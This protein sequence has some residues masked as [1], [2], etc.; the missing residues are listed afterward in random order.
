MQ[1]GYSDRINHALAFAAKHHDG[2]VR[3]GTA[4]PYLTQP[5]NVAIILTR[6]GQPE[7]TVVSGILHD[8]VE[9]WV[10]DGYTADELDDRIG[11]KFGTVVLET[12]LA[13]TRRRHDDDGIELSAD[14]QKADY[15]SRLTTA[16]DAARWVCCA[17]L[18]HHAGGLL[19][20]L[21]RTIDANVVWSRQSG[22]RSGTL[23][24]FSGVVERLDSLGWHAPVLDELRSLTHALQQQP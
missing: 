6:Y 9:D 16:S 5:A 19:A 18:V 7:D 8:V 4:A 1:P 17:D 11:R 10:R 23:H 13:V 20:D 21:R 14:E 12:L 22:G 24:W 2:Q 15:L 3:K